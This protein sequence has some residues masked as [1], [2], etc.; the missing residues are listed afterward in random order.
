[1]TASKPDATPRTDKLDLAWENTTQS[2]ASQGEFTDAYY[3]MLEH[4]RQLE[5]ELN[6]ANEKAHSYYCELSSA[7][8]VG[9][10]EGIEEAAKLIDERATARHGHDK[11]GDAQAIRLLSGEGK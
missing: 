3:A 10:N 2:V 4:A 8:L 6:E 1:M 7:R 5:T 9:Y 11:H